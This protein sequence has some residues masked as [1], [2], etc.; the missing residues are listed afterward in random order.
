MEKPK[1]KIE[2]VAVR[3]GERFELAWEDQIVDVTVGQEYSYSESGS[4]PVYTLLVLR[5]GV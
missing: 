4:V 5:R 3:A 2:Q 1:A